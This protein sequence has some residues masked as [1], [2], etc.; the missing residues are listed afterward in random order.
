MLTICS[1]GHNIT[2]LWMEKQKHFALLEGSIASGEIQIIQRTKQWLDAYFSGENPTI[3]HIPLRPAG[4]HFQQQVWQKLMEIPYGQT[5]TYGQIAADFNNQ[6]MSAQAVGNAVGRN[7]I[8]ILI[9]CHR[10]V[11]AKGL[12]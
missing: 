3:E 5:V 7:P 2:G 11:G 12:S 8:C 9:P 6:K 4:T 1:D 10:V